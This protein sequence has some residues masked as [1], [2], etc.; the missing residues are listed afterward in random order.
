VLRALPPATKAQRRE[1]VIIRTEGLR[2]VFKSRAGLVEAVRGVDLTVEAGTIFGFLGP[3]G[4]GK[5]TTV[6]LLATLLTPDDGRAVVAG[7]DLLAEPAEVRARIGYVSQAGGIDLASTPRRNLLLHGRLYGLGQA[8]AGA[9][10]AEL[11]D[12]LDLAEVAGR[13]AR[14]LS[15]GQRRRLALALGMLHRPALLF[16]DEP[17]VGLDPQG[18]ARLWDEVRTLRET[19]TSVFLTTQYLDEADQLADRVAIIDHGRIVAE[20]TPAALKRQI[21]G[22]VVTLH[23]DGGDTSRSRA[24]G[25]LAALPCTREITEDGGALRVYVERGSENL[26]GLLRALDG[27]RLP[28]RSIALA[29]PT[30]DDVFLRQT[31]R[32]LREAPAA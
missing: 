25:L 5:T 7:Y 19:G 24:S 29:S 14:T 8:R 10:A 27:E 16:L 31:G 21:A 26:P 17:T 12:A 23:L 3:N 4:A 28:V 15:G 20:D 9:R 2:K 1:N 11:L 32:S 18:R 13:P 30:L 6:R 22:D